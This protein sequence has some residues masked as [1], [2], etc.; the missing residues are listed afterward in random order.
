MPQLVTQQGFVLRGILYRVGQ[1]GICIFVVSCGSV[2]PG[3]CRFDNILEKC[4][5]HLA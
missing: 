3:Y 2:F 5:E 4:N 1:G